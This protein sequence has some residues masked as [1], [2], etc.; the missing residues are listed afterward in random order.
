M[1]LGDFVRYDPWKQERLES[2]EVAQARLREKPSI[3]ADQ[4]LGYV[5]LD[6]QGHGNEDGDSMA[7]DS[8]VS[9]VKISG[10]FP[11]A[12]GSGIDPVVND[13]GAVPGGNEGSSVVPV[14]VGTG[15]VPTRTGRTIGGGGPF[16]P[17]VRAFQETDGDE[18]AVPGNLTTVRIFLRDCGIDPNE[19]PRGRTGFVSWFWSISGLVRVPCCAG[20][21]RIACM[22]RASVGMTT[23]IRP[24]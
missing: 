1:A 15:Y 6:E 4:R 16:D 7:V 10:T 8:G 9:R 17:V 5:H 12:G 2:Y 14:S 21:A 18:L 23:M 13:S 20:I 3:P 22:R 11:G 19:M 24:N